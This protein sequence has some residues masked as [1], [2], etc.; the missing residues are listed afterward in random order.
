MV[1]A[2]PALA[3]VLL[4]PGLSEPPKAQHAPNATA[5]KGAKMAMEATTPARWA[6]FMR[7]G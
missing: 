3:S 4:A 5:A 6:A 2:P 7:E 1:G